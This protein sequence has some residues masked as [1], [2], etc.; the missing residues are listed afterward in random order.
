MKRAVREDYSNATDMADY[1]V[2]KG[3]PFREAHEVIGKTVLYAIEH[4]KYLLDLTL[5]EYKQFSPL[6]E[7]DIFEV[8][9]PERVVG[10]RKSVGG[11]AP[12]QVEQQIQ[13]AEQ[14]L[15]DAH[16]S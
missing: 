11:T 3:M 6:F 4:Q 7:E 13:L 8:L 5:D 15:S 1:L 12:E 9:Q 14:K 16:R 2:T 10:A